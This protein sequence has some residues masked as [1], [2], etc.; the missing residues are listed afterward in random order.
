MFEE[1]ESIPEENMKKMEGLLQK[2][3]NERGVPPE[4]A[5]EA[6]DSGSVAQEG[7]GLLPGTSHVSRPSKGHGLGS[8]V[9]GQSGLSRHHPRAPQCLE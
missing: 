7:R 9:G 4:P 3:E 8:G 2:G 6:G 1:K 5:L